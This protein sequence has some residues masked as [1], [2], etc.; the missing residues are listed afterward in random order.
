VQSLGFFFFLGKGR[1]GFNFFVLK[2]FSKKIK[3]LAGKV[4]NKGLESGFFLVQLVVTLAV[5]FILQV[6]LCAGSSLT[7]NGDR[8]AR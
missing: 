4:K 6:C 5:Q 8:D 2:I 3:I 7:L 1:C